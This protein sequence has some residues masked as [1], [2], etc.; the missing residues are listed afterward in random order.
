M[1]NIL[2]AFVLLFAIHVQAQ[3]NQRA[4]DS[5]RKL[6]ETDYRT[7]LVQLDIDSI[8][9]GANGN[10]PNAPNAANY[11]ESKANPYPVLPDPLVLKNGKHVKD[12][13]TWW[14]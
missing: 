1:R 10:N 2:C 8:R 7:M 5:I 11:D 6:T 14:Q 13:V 9:P 3:F 12:A 4:M